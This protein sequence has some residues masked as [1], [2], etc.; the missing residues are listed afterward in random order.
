MSKA[1]LKD[2]IYKIFF[3]GK[4]FKKKMSNV[5]RKTMINEGNIFVGDDLMEMYAFAALYS[6]FPNGKEYAGFKLADGRVIL[7]LDLNRT[8]HS[9]AY[10]SFTP[11]CING[12]NVPLYDGVA[13]TGTFHTHTSNTELEMSNEDY[14]NYMYYFS[15][16]Q[17]VILYGNTAYIY[18][19][20]NGV[21]NGVY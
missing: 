4:L 7:L 8:D 3:D 11:Q 5:R 17:N 18:N 21:C 19:F 15:D 14:A 1:L 20:S 16:Q 13:I 10:P 2:R 9:A 12:Y 6:S